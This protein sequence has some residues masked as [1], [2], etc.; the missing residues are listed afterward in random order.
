MR[1]AIVQGTPHPDVSLFL[2]LSAL[3]NLARVIGVT[4]PEL[5]EMPESV[6]DALLQANGVVGDLMTEAREQ[7]RR[8]AKR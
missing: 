7:A 8:Q 6:V 4:T 5:L 3:A 2:A 1:R